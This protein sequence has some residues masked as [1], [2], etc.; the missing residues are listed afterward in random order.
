[1]PEAR[2]RNRTRSSTR[3]HLADEGATRALAQCCADG[4]G[5]GDCFLLSGPL[6]SGKSAF[7]RGFIRHLAGAGTEVPSPTF[8]LV[9]PYD[10]PRGEIWHADFYR[11][12][13]PDEIEETGL[14]DAFPRAIS[15]IEWPDRLGPE[16]PL[17]YVGITL[18]PVPGDETARQAVLRTEGDGWEWLTRALTNPTGQWQG[19]SAML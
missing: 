3:L 14:F 18:S 12:S 4:A 15:L 1:M 6:G 7:A 5:A 9:Q 11:L 2:T 16:T 13:G 10:T 19:E 17:R 8:T